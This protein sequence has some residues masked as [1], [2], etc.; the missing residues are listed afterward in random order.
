MGNRRTAGDASARSLDILRLTAKVDR[1]RQESSSL[2]THSQTCEVEIPPEEW[3]SFLNAFS[4][5]HEG[6]LGTLSVTQIDEQRTEV[7]GCRL[8]DISSHHLRPGHEIYLTLAR[9][10]GWQVA[11]RIKDP[12]RVVFRRDLEG[13][14]EG[15]DINS[16][17]GTLTSIRFR[18]TARPETLDGVL[19]D[20]RHDIGQHSNTGSAVH[21]ST[22]PRKEK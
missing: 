14:H 6:W 15:L 11:S 2:A 3:H 7:R 12:A 19:T 17:D 20:T 21:K 16:A 5:Q 13:A 9:N 4:R 1:M 22:K 8:E 10:D 18:V